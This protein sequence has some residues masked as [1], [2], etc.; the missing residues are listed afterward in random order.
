MSKQYFELLEGVDPQP[1]DVRIVVAPSR[2]LKEH[3]RLVTFRPCDPEPANPWIKGSDRLP[4]EEDATLEGYVG[5]YHDSLDYPAM[6][7]FSSVKESDYWRKIDQTPPP[8]VPEPEPVPDPETEAEPNPNNPQ[9]L[10]NAVHEKEGC[11]PEMLKLAREAEKQINELKAQHAA[12]LQVLLEWVDANANVG[13]RLKAE[14]GKS[15]VLEHHFQSTG[16]ALAA[17]RA[18]AALCEHVE[19]LVGS[20]GRDGEA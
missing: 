20:E 5:V 13:V 12:T 19:A 4:T 7:Y 6:F 8:A 18:N 14:F 15:Y 16:E 11:A 10:R 17:C 1:G 3:P 2:S 9:F